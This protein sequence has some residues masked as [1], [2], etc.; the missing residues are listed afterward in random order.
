MCSK[1]KLVDLFQRVVGFGIS[2]ISCIVSYKNISSFTVLPETFIFFSFLDSF[3]IWSRKNASVSFDVYVGP[4][5]SPDAT[6]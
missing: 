5:F 6:T 4:S 3:A 1:S 2:Y